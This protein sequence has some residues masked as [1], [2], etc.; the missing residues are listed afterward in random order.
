MKEN[1]SGILHSDGLFTKYYYDN[2]DNE[3]YNYLFNSNCPTERTLDLFCPICQN[4]SVFSPIKDKYSLYEQT[5][6]NSQLGNDS[7]STANNE[8]KDKW[9]RGLNLI[10]REF[11][12]SREKNDSRHNFI[13]IF[14]FFN[15]YF[16]KIAQYPS[17]ADLTNPDIKKYKKLDNEIFIE[18]SKGVGLFSHGIGV[19]SFVYLRRI[20]EN[21][22]VRPQLA[23]LLENKQITAEELYQKDFKEKLKLLRGTISDFLVSNQVI[24]SVLSK[25]IHE[26]SEEECL[27]HF[28]VLK[29]CIEFILDEQIELKEKDKKR[30]QLSNELNRL[31]I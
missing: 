14:K 19:G 9:L 23:V 13:V 18:L 22:I 4:N 27:M 30:K 29:T 25:G 10:K 2:F 3:V 11:S 8:N 24:Y 7:P 12:C 6:I 21:Y 26:L 1:I 5:Y 28:P 20:I 31:K 15:D 16:V 17:V